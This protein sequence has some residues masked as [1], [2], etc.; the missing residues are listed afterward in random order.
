MIVVDSSVWIS[1]FDRVHNRAAAKLVAIPDKA[2]ILV[3]DLVLLE[4]LQGARDEHHAARLERELRAFEIVPL[5][6]EE[7]AVRAASNY[8]TLRGLGRTIRKSADLIIAT[9][10][11]LEGHVLLHDDRDFTPFEQHLGLRCL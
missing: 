8:R 1:V 11:I 7:I 2:R 10:C 5:L 4:V 9:F 6:D 3:G